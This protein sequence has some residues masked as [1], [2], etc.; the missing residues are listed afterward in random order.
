MVL[1]IGRDGTCLG[2]LL[3]SAENMLEAL[4]S[5]H[6]PVAGAVLGTHIGCPLAFQFLGNIRRIDGGHL[7]EVWKF[8]SA[9]T[10]CTVSIGE[11]DD[12]SHVLQGYL[13]GHIG[14]IEAVGR[15]GGSHHRHG[16]LT[17]TA[18][19]SLQ[20]VGLFRLRGK[21]RGRTAALN[22]EHYQWQ[23][24]DDGK[25]HGLTLQADARTRGR[26]HAQST[27]KRSTE[28]RSTARDFVLTLH[29][30]DTQRLV[31]RQFVEH[32]GSR[33][34]G[35]R[36]QIKLQ[37]GLLGSSNE[38][39]GRGLITRDIHIAARLLHLRLDAIHVHSRR[40]RVVAIVVASLNHLDIGLSDGGLLGKFLLEE[41][42]HQVQ[43]AVEEPADE[44]QGE[45]IAAFQH[46]LVVHSRVGQG[47]FHHLRER[48]LDDAVGI[49][50][51]LAEIVFRLEGSLLQVVGTER[52]RVDN[53][54]GLWL[55]IL[56]LRL[57][58]SSVHGHQHVGL[59]A[60]RVN[61]SGTDMHLKAG[62]TRQ[63][64]LRGADVGGIVWK[65]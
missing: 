49:N 23:L 25:V 3:Q 38:T 32:V 44:S 13:A 35:V 43:V 19:E 47:V 52:I 9:R 5:G 17:V 11:Q 31:L 14:G 12:G 56:Q 53:D 50:T 33:R 21:T 54:R 22:V 55:G 8:E 34:D 20:E 1:R 15:T 42:E 6:C 27:G 62:D 28:G 4:A 2:I 30:G 36:T 51:H 63:R 58:R 59:I 46:G 26:S 29:R 24:H 37:S 18:K 39:V 41:I 45:H 64:T 10:V 48:A 7:V 60:R 16:T 61:L 65:C 57:Q 40:M